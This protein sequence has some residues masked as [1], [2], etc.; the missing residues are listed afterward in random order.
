RIRIIVPLLGG[1]FG[2]KTYAKIEPLAGA[3]ARITGRPV[4]L[5]LSADDAFRTVRRCDS[6]V[7]VRLGFRRDGSCVA[8]LCRAEF[9]VGA[10]ADIGPRIIQKG[11]YTATGPYRVP[12]VLLHSD[13]VYTNT[14]PGGAFRGCGV[15]QIAWAVES[16]ID[17]AADRLGRDP[18][19][20]RRQN[21]LAHGEEF[22][23]GDTPV[24]GK[25]EESLA[26]AAEAI[27]WSESGAADSGRGIAMMMNAS[28][29]PAGSR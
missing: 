10:Y 12:H 25:F 22:A 24:D 8:A 15:P 21:L 7:R 26:Q 11:T 28:G 6:R 9:D 17:D 5:A 27:R 19:D 4:R 1:G 3:L 20:L 2:S 13:A 23:A 16:L 14:T 18:V 29:A